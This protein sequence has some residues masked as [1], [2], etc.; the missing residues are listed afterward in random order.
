MDAGISRRD[1]AYCTPQWSD[2]SIA[3]IHAARIGV[4]DPLHQGMTHHILAGEVG[5]ADAGNLIQDRFGMTQARGH[6][7][8]QVH[9]GGI[10]RDDGGRAESK[11]RSRGALALLP[12]H[13]E[14]R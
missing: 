4:D 7:A 8:R 10:A 13:R 11:P 14:S 6:L 12:R 1:T 9:L 5:K 2:G 3:A